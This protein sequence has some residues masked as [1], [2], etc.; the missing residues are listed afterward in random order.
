M[1]K[2]HHR[3]DW[4]PHFHWQLQLKKNSVYVNESMSAYWAE[5]GS[6]VSL[7]QNILWVPERIFAMWWYLLIKWT[8]H[9]KY[10]AVF[11]IQTTMAQV[12]FTARP[13]DKSAY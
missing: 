2:L 3:I 5:Y 6:F 10:S 7:N 13:P 8:T 12:L 9:E 1:L 4:K 11:W